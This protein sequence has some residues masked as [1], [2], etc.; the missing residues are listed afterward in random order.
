MYE[1]K[2][3]DIQSLK[4]PI[5]KLKPTEMPAQ[6]W[7]ADDLSIKRNQNGKKLDEDEIEKREKRESQL[8]EMEEPLYVLLE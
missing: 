1:Q 5:W 3:K 2:L 8:K 7:Y 4:V 6:P